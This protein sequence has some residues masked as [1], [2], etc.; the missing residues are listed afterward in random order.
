[1]L[2]T[3]SHGTPRC[4][5]RPKRRVG[6][7]KGPFNMDVDNNYK[8]TEGIDKKSRH[9]VTFRT[10]LYK[11]RGGQFATSTKEVGNSDRRKPWTKPL[12]LRLHYDTVRTRTWSSIKRV[13]TKT[14]TLGNRIGSFDPTWLLVS[15][16]EVAQMFRETFVDQET[17]R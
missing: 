8:T 5:T 4:K 10:G 15:A 6:W 7:V 2:D 14:R 16:E 9:H 12:V 11:Q 1:M 3:V 13:Y 17:A